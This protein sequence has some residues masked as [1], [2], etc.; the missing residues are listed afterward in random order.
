MMMQ[1]QILITIIFINTVMI[2]DK[3]NQNISLKETSYKTKSISEVLVC[4]QDILHT[5]WI[6]VSQHTSI[7]PLLNVITIKVNTILPSVRHVIYWSIVF[8]SV[9]V[10]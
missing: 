6:D 9:P 4:D 8:L 7:S 3:L 2:A 1:L 10:A 5:K